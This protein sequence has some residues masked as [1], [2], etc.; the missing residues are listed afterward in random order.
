MPDIFLGENENKPQENT[1]DSSE[2]HKNNAKKE[3][4]KAGSEELNKGIPTLKEDKKH[5]HTHLLAAY[6]E[7][8]QEVSFAD[9]LEDEEILLFLRRHFIT[10]IPWVIKAILLGLVPLLFSAINMLGVID[11]NFLTPNYLI[12]ILLFYYF[13]ILGYIFA[14][15]LTW[16]YNISLVTSKRIVDI[17]FSQIVFENVDATKLTQVEDVGYVQVGVIR[18]IFDYGDVHL[19]T[20][21]PASDFEFLA[22]PHPERVL[23]VIN[24]LIGEANNA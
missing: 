17:D 12:M 2:S 8:P 13:L 14:N 3:L 9:K 21:G 24:N 7:N 23:K 22:V 6:C 20:A 16:F 1:P 10:N 19:H 5:N 15:Y 4:V 11:I 18:S